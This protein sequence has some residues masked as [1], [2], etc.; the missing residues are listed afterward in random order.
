[1][2]R[3]STSDPLHRPRCGRLRFSLKWLATKSE[4]APTDRKIDEEVY[5]LYGL[6]ADEIKIAENFDKNK[7][8]E[9]KN[10]IQKGNIAI[11]ALEMA[12]FLTQ[13]LDPEIISN[14]S[15]VITKVGQVIA[16]HFL[17][18]FFSEYKEKVNRHDLKS[19]GFATKNPHLF[20]LIY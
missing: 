10:K 17:S 7:I 11:T 12:P 16:T 4:I 5:K 8:D 14:P 3:K 13:L 15:L 1:M 6:T 2:S 18:E 9:R 20:F 19:G